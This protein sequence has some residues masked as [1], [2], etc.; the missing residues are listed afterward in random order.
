VGA[1][2]VAAG[3]DDDDA[4]EGTQPDDLVVPSAGCHARLQPADSQHIA[5]MDAH[6]HHYFANPLVREKLAAWLA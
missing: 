1:H 4:R 2:Y 3:G 6:H 5:G